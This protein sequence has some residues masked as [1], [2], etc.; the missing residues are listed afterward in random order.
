MSEKILI[1][2]NGAVI[3]EQEKNVSDFFKYCEDR[4]P[5]GDWEPLT[6]EKLQDAFDQVHDDLTAHEK[7]KNRWEHIL[8]ISRFN[9]KETEEAYEKI[10]FYD[11]QIEQITHT[12]HIFGMLMDII[13]L[14]SMH[15]NEIEI[16]WMIIEE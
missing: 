1:N 16:K 2:L 4:A 11:Q 3:M 7:G 6:L 9:P 15:G 10:E 12:L 8:Q 5:K 13:K 14:N